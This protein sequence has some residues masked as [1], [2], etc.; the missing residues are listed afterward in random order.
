M[1]E[2]KAVKSAEER[3]AEARATL[4][5]AQQ[6]AAEAASGVMAAKMRAVPPITIE[7]MPGTAVGEGGKMY[8]GEGYALAPDGHKGNDRLTLDGP[9]ALALMQTG[10]VTFVGID[11]QQTKGGQK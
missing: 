4:E 11:D 2:D 8:Y 1:A 9:T 7:V 5:Q 6:D 3:L 10:H